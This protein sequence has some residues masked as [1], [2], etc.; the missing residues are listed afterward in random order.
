MNL[1]TLGDRMLNLASVMAC[2]ELLARLL[3]DPYAP[4]KLGN[5]ERALTGGAP[6]ICSSSL[7]G[8]ER[9]PRITLET[10]AGAAE[11]DVGRAT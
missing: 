10:G 2:A 3:A 1:M 9:Y 4:A 7:L 11:S 5:V 6:M 8:V